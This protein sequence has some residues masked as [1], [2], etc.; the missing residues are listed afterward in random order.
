[1]TD[2]R[3]AIL[4]YAES[5]NSF[6]FS[7]LLNYMND[8]A[9]ISKGTL[10]WHLREMVKDCILFKLGR[11]I[12]TRHTQKIVEYKP[13]IR[14]KGVSLYKKII[15][16]FPFISV[17]VFDGQVLADFQQHLSTNNIIYVE[18]DRDATEAVFHFLKKLGETVFLDPSNDFVY[19]N[20]DLSKDAIIVKPLVTEAPLKEYDGI[21]TSSLEKIIVDI[22][23]DD[24]LDYL[25]GAEWSHIFENAFNMY[26]INRTT[27]L[28]Y[29][30]RR[31]VKAQIE[32]KLNDLSNH[33]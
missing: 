19:D 24:D 2:T 11:G 26:P 9:R 8:V 31:N 17:S 20:I 33:D 22:F 16:E 10:S 13:R 29:A 27:M 12:Y 6:K 18:V 28:R 15:R 32:N 3:I 23:C 7:D 21:K 25:H 4:N 1:M 30:S 14:R 5:R